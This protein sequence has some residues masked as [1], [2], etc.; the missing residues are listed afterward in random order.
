MKGP[1]TIDS[2]LRN[3]GK[4]RTREVK[5]RRSARELVSWKARVP[6]EG[7]KEFRKEADRVLAELEQLEKQ[8]EMLEAFGDEMLKRPDR[9]L[10]EQEA[11]CIV[12][13]LQGIRKVG[14]K[15]VIPAG[16]GNKFM[17]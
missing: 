13:D 2:F 11:A 5:A 12:A 7:R 9:R 3:L 4:L 10:S 15:I 16:V 17:N 14:T 8:R 1:I 6:L